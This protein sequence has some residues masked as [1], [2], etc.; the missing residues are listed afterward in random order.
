MNHS[1]PFFGREVQELKVK[2]VLA[3][4]WRQLA[5]FLLFISLQLLV[6]FSTLIK[7]LT[8]QLTTNNKLSYPPN[9]PPPK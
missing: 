7:Y 5:H 9:T 2:D 8:F 3:T 1:I 4:G 6:L